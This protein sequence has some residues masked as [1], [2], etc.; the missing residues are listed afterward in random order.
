MA[1]GEKRCRS[2][3]KL[4]KQ[5]RRWLSKPPEERAALIAVQKST[6]LAKAQATNKR[7]A[8]RVASAQ[9]ELWSVKQAHARRGSEP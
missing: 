8:A 6:D 1:K 4:N 9:G 3:A 2:V 5:T 7:F